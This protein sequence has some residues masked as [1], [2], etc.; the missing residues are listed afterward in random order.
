MLLSDFGI[1][2]IPNSPVSLTGSTLL[3][4]PAYISPEQV[5]GKKVEPRSDQYS[6]GVLL[7]QLTTGELPFV[8]DSPAAVLLQHIHDPLP[9]PREL[10]PAISES[11][12]QVILKMTAKDPRHRFSSVAMMNTVF[13]K[14]VAHAF[15]AEAHP[16]P[17][18][19]VLP[20]PEKPEEATEEPAPD[21]EN[22]IRR[23][24]NVVRLTLL[25]LAI[26]SIGAVSAMSLQG[27]FANTNVSVQE[28]IVAELTTQA[29]IIKELSTEIERT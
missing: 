21:Q 27:R 4:T 13:Q 7:F 17:K 18:I 16:A 2:Y 12:E 1:A 23:S 15:D 20:Y 25:F 14:A 3:G 10:N 28:K 19:Q 26:I 29:G 5:L 11:V 8:A 9:L 24:S 6:L 22:W